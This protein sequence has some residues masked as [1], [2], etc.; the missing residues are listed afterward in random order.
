MMSNFSKKDANNLAKLFQ[1][2]APTIPDESLRKELSKTSLQLK[3][4]S[5]TAIDIK[6]LIL[7]Q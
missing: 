1:E 4:A 5:K 7:G 6:I 2:T 3:E